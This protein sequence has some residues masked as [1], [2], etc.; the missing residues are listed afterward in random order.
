MS[1][2]GRIVLSSRLS[3]DGE[4]VDGKCHG[5]GH[6]T[7]VNG[8]KYVGE[9]CDGKRGG[10]GQLVTAEGHTV[11]PRGQLGGILACGSWGV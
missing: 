5:K 11:R 1:G 8:D 3:Y 7:Y 6:C 9:Y 4:W 10:Y 2:R